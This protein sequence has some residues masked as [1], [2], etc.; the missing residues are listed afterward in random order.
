V[1]TNTRCS[2][3]TFV[4]EKISIEQ[5]SFGGLLWVGGWLFTIGFLKLTFWKGVLAG[6]SPP[7]EYVVH[8]AE[9]LAPRESAD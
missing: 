6:S 7:A 4:M 3:K 1:S 2:A 8:D 9:Q 5:H